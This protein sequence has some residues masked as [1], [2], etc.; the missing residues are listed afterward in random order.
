MQQLGTQDE[1]HG[2]RAERQGAAIGEQCGHAAFAGRFTGRGRVPFESED[3]QRDPAPR[4]AA[5]GLAR[6]VA[7]ARADI[8]QRDRRA[9]GTPARN[10][11]SRRMAAAAPPNARLIRAMS[12]SEATTTPASAPGSSSSSSASAAQRCGVRHHG[13][14]RPYVERK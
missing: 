2:A 1:I 12:R 9:A 13:A 7:R 6:D 5:R 11:S 3:A 10:S 8:E 14:R 4:G